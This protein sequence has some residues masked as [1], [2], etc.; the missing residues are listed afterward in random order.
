MIPHGHYIYQT[1]YYT[2]ATM[3]AYPQSQHILPHW[4]CVLSFCAK[5]PHID[6]I[7][8]ESDKNTSNT[9]PTIHFNVL[10]LYLSIRFMVDVHLTKQMYVV[11]CY[12]TNCTNLK[13]IHKKISYNDGDIDFWLFHKFLHTINKKAINTCDTCMN[14]RDS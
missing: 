8:Q 1:S 11:F 2:V 3:C 14:S 5:F 13:Y 9:C 7:I 12:A 10:K 4:K 6:I